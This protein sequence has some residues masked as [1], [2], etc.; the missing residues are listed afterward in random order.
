ALIFLPGDELRYAVVR[1][2]DGVGDNRTVDQVEHRAEHHAAGAFTLASALARRLAEKVEEAAR[3]L[4]TGIQQL[5]SP[6]AARLTGK[7]RHGAGGPVDGV[8]QH[9]GRQPA[10]QGVRVVDL[11]VLIPLIGG[12][13]VLIDARLA[14]RPH[15][16]LGVE[17]ALDKLLGQTVEELRIARRVAGADIIH[18]LDEPN[19]EQVAPNAVDV[20][21]GEVWILFGSRPP[22]ELLAARPLR[23]NLLGDLIREHGRCGDA[24]PLVLHLTGGLVENDF[25]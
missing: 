3:H 14:N 17:A 11:V 1:I 5:G 18:W 21:L 6:D 23:R 22:G 25:D 24:G 8:K 19:A 10:R 13:G 9:L 20:A 4:N 2:L 12:D 16:L 15:D 7:L